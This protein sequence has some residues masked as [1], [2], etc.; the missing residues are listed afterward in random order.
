MVERCPVCGLYHT[1]PCS[2]EKAEEE[3]IK[4]AKKLL[5]EVKVPILKLEKPKIQYVETKLNKTIPQLR[6]DTADLFITRVESK[7]LRD[8]IGSDNYSKMF[9]EMLKER[10]K[11]VEMFGEKV[12]ADNPDFNRVVERFVEEMK[13]KYFVQFFKL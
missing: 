1:P 6:F 5:E 13:K 3:I 12:D 4:Q 11:A 2:E 10:R 8:L 9:K 7:L